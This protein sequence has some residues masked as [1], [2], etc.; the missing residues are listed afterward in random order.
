[1]VITARCVVIEAL[2]ATSNVLVVGTTGLVTRRH[3]KGAEK[4]SDK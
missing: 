1:M 4:A 2:A 3:A